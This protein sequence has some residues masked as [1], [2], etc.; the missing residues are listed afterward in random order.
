METHKAIAGWA[1]VEVAEALESYA[2]SHGIKPSQ[3]VV[4][5]VVKGLRMRKPTVRKVGRPSKA[6]LNN[7]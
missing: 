2:K 6:L 3:A 7:S 5:F 1:P 4:N